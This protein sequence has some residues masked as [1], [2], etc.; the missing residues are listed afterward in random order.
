MVF[1]LICRDGR[2]PKTSGLLPTIHGPK[3]LYEVYLSYSSPHDRTCEN[4]F[5]VSDFYRSELMKYCNSTR[6]EKMH[7]VRLGVESGRLQTF[8]LKNR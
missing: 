7:A 6:W 3:E 5:C 2:D 4:H 8:A 1:R